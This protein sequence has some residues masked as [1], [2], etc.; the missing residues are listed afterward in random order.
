MGAV[1]RRAGNG[2]GEGRRDNRRGSAEGSMVEAAEETRIFS[3]GAREIDVPLL[4]GN[5]TNEIREVWLE[6]S[7]V[8]FAGDEKGVSF[9]LNGD[10]AK[11]RR[12]GVQ[13]EETRCAGSRA[14]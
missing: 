3:K 6:T 5:A 1:G 9:F 12:R 14:P 10:F 4:V 8:G 2:E 7:S 11:I 13:L